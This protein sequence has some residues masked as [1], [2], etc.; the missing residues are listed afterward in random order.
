MKQKDPLVLHVAAVMLL[1]FLSL[2]AIFRIGAAPTQ[3]AG[4]SGRF[5]APY[6]DMTLFPTPSLTQITQTSGL[7]FYSLAFI[8]N[9]NTG[10]CLAAWGGSVTFAQESTFLPNL[11]SDIQ[12]VRSQGGDVTVSFGG[13]AGTELADS[14]TSASALQAQYQS[15]I[16]RYHLTHIDFDIEGVAVT[17]Q[18]SIDMRNKAIA[19]LQQANPGLF[20]SYTLPV[21]PS[22]LVDTGINILKNAIQNGVAIGVVNVMAMD[23]GSSFPSDMGQ[24]AINAGN[25]LFS[26]LKTLFPSKTDS[27]LHAMIGITP[28][29]GINDINTEIF[30]EQN[31]QQL[32][33]YAQQN[34]IGELA[35]WSEGRDKQCTNPTGFASPSCSGINQQAFDFTNIFNPFNGVVTPPTVTPVPTQTVTPT[36]TATPPPGV[37]PWDPNSHV[38][39]VGDQVFFQGHVYQCLQAHT[40]QPGWDPAAVPALWQLIS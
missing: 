34:Q 29:I 31:A 15:V 23:Y 26:Q 7:K 5:F 19:A 13:Q 3:A 9:A 20:V 40:S 27:Q 18:N 36:P 35:M 28:M 30:T 8:T 17:E 39:H 6:T 22:G 24:N 12:F 2:I 14:C 10:T 25:S 1:C 11:Q 4:F 16:D 21:L 38:Y 33:A 37:Q 32:L